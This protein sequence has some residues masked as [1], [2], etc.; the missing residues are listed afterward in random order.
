MPPKA[1]ENKMVS[2]QKRK[3]CRKKCHK[4]FQVLQW[5]FDWRRKS[6][7]RKKE[8]KEEKNTLSELN[9]CVNFEIIVLIFRAKLNYVCDL[10]FP[11]PLSEKVKIPRRRNC[12]RVCVCDTN[13]QKNYQTHTHPNTIWG[14]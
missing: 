11:S 10:W 14:I 3:K 2:T 8:R 12:V 7:E 6:V 1:T 4:I 5:Y 13:I 9:N